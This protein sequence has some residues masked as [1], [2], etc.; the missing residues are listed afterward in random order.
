MQEEA[1]WNH[2]GE[3]GFV[4]KLS[5]VSALTRRARVASEEIDL[6]RFKYVTSKYRTSYPSCID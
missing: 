3:F 5:E 1:S 4:K 2:S 6:F